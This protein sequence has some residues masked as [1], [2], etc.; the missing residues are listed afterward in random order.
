MNFTKEPL[1]FAII[2]K[3]ASS[4]LWEGWMIYFSFVFQGKQFF[5][6]GTQNKTS[7]KCN[8]FLLTLKLSFLMHYLSLMVSA[9]AVMILNF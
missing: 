4:P 6:L 7:C 9:E 3:R 8:S 1:K 2:L 5:V